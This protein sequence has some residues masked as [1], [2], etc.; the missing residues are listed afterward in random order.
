MDGKILF[1][2]DDILFWARVRDAARAAGREAL[3]IGDEAAM[4][5]AFRSGG[6]ARVIADLGSR[7]VDVLAW[8]ARW[9]A[10]SPAPELIAYGSHVDEHA[11]AAARDAGFDL[12][13]PN[14]RFNRELGRLV[15]S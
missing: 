6:V 9:K 12:V 11:L 4:D 7:S 8:A 2:S 5:A 14:S 15:Q 3:R 10:A 13:M 1:V